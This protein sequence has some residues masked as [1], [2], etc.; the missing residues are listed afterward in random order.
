LGRQLSSSASVGVGKA[1]KHVEEANEG[2][3]VLRC[4]AVSSG[5][6]FPKFRIIN[7]IM[8][9]KSSKKIANVDI[10]TDVLVI[11]ALALKADAVGLSE[12][13]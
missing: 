3:N 9:V 4:Y 10:T 12:M 11:T 6:S 5:K 2:T 13:S 7:Y 8:K 1:T